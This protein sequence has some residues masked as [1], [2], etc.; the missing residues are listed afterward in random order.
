[1]RK[2]LTIF[3]T[4]CISLFS[5]LTTTVFATTFTLGGTDLTIDVDDS[6]WYVFTRDNLE[7]NPEL[8]ELG[9]TSEDVTN[10]LHTYNAYMDAVLFYEDGEYLE[11][12]VV[13]ETNDGE[14]KM[15]A[16]IKAIT[17]INLTKIFIEGPA[18]SFNGSPTVSPVT[19]VL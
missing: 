17:D 7:N 11:C 19:A 8:D 12:F 9:L 16:I 1:M 18:V 5:L 4:I 14:A 3:T 2:K 15:G 13:K 10:I 6:I